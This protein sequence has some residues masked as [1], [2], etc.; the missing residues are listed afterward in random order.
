MKK[1]YIKFLIEYVCKVVDIEFLITDVL[2]KI[3]DESFCIIG[4]L[5][6]DAILS[7]LIQKEYVSIFDIVKNSGD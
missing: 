5:E 2:S 7:S 4:E 1:S 3:D 6:D